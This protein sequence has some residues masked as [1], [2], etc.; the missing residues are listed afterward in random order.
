[1]H[2]C[3]MYKNVD[4]IF[5]ER[6]PL[7]FDTLLPY[8]SPQELDLLSEEFTEYQLLQVADIPHNIW[9]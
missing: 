1:M 4:M 8:K 9:D 7:R 6:F 2:C 3:N 5:R